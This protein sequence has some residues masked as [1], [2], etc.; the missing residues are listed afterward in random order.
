MYFLEFFIVF[1]IALFIIVYRKND[2]TESFYKFVKK[3]FGVVYQKYAPYS[4]QTISAKMKELN[5]E[6]TIK[7]YAI[8]VIVIGGLA[9]AIAYLYFY[10]LIMVIIYAG[11][12]IALIPYL[13]FLRS[14]RIY[15]EYL[16]EQIQVYTTNVIMEFNTTQSFVKS[17]EGVRDSGIIENPVLDDIKTMINMSYQNGTIDESIEFFNSKYP[18]Y[19]VKNMHQLFLQITKEGAKDSGEALEN[20]SMDIDSLVEGVYRDQM[21]RKQFHTKFITFALVLFLLVLVMQVLLGKDSYLQ[22]LELWYVHI[23]LHGIILINCYFLITGE[24]YYNEDV[25]GE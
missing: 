7:D 12:A 20:M 11:I 3:Q 22:L 25:G 17:L 23:V 2:G 18:Y 19:M 13:A 4:F 21:D 1:M 10:S 8:Q 15:S 14:K 24:K 5:Q 6:Y 16:F 9:A